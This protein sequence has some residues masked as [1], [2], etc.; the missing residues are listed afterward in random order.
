MDSKKNE[1][2]K[3]AKPLTDEET[4]N[5]TAG[6]KVATTEGESS[7]WKTLVDLFFKNKS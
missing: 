5:V 7:W 1:T 6:M 3:E 2:V 4:E